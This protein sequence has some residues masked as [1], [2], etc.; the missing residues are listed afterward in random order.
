MLIILDLAP[1][2]YSG[3]SGSAVPQLLGIAL[4]A[5]WR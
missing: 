5:I 3:H 4:S 1:A 2:G